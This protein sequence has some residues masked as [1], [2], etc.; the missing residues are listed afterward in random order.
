MA[1][2]YS[3]SNMFLMKKNIDYVCIDLY[4]E[5]FP[6]LPNC[7]KMNVLDL[8][9]PENTFDFVISNHVMEHIEDEEMFIKEITRVLK[10]D[11]K[12]IIS[13]PC[14]YSLKET[15]EDYTITSPEERLK[16]FGQ[17]DHVRKYGADIFDRISNYAKVTPINRDAYNGFIDSKISL[18]YADAVMLVEKLNKD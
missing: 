11:G 15:V 4:P 17:E 6:Y 3:I 8:K 13:A 9:F 16:A 10:P 2:E 5:N 14:D 18:G 12:A 7:L 1:P